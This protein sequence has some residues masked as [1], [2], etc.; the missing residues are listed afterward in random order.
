[1]S[2]YP[3]LLAPLDLGAFTVANRVVMGAMHTRLE[4][5]DRPTERAVAFMRARA[6]GEVGLILTGGHAPSE[7]GRMDPES[8]VLDHES[9]LEHH[10]AVCA[11]V[12]G[13]GSRIVLQI[14]HAGR[15]GQVPSCVGPSAARAPINPYAPRALS[16]EEVWEIVDQFAHTASLARAADYDGVEIMGSE[17]YLISQFAALSTNDRNDEFGGDLQGRLRLPLEILRAVRDAVGPQL[18]VIYRISAL[19]LVDG[20]LTGAETCALARSVEHAGA[21]V[22][23]TGIGWH[24]SRVPTVA[25]SVPRAAWAFAVRS[26]KRAVCVP[27]IASNRINT[28]EV[29]EALLA[30]GTADLVSMARPLL[31]DPN[32]VRKARLGRSDEI[33]P[34]IACNQACLDRIFT[35]RTASCML[36]P[37]AGRE[38]EFPATE[39]PN[40]KRI[41]VVGGGPAGMAFALNAA[42]RGHRVTLFEAAPDLGGQLN[43][44]RRVPGKG[45]FDEALRYF[46]VRL[47]AE[48]VVVRTSTKVTAD[49]LGATE[50]DE[51]V[52]AT[53]V[54]PRRPELSGVDHPKVTSY[55]EILNG[56]RIAG[57]SVAIIGAGG[58]GFD[59][60]EFLVGR[61]DDS[62][63]PKA[64]L[65]AWGV[66]E[67]MQ[68]PGGLANGTAPPTHDRV[69]AVTM[70]QR[71]DASLGRSLGKSTG[72]ILKSRLRKA[73]VEM[74]PG[75]T[76]HAIDDEGLHFTAGRERRR[77]DVDTVVICAGQESE[78]SLYDELVASG[79]RPHI[80]GGAH[81][82]AE[83]DAVAAIDQAT[84]LAIEI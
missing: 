59:V 58:I 82:A 8:P 18:L 74:V 36:N 83:L 9:Q 75:A 47:R 4:T 51:L 15:Y 62:T 43:L 21:D 71:K 7:A 60:A 44:A 29:A 32:F 5:L 68:T 66:D 72:W 26:I 20:G 84:R 1:L 37:R 14:L 39:A 77:I 55:V 42:E 24:E 61:E 49:D 16:T 78:R 27:V 56:A 10:R 53:G 65:V 76:Y 3:H 11:A 12:H 69:R 30:D 52:I 2:A 17:G 48:G 28:P 33:N 45:E 23:N 81:T 13:A 22:I 73:G 6:R 38:I 64:F 79:R 35:D 31:V 41:G 34:C 80:I 57:R 46:R 50:F 40:P 19:D 67:A 54:T 70:L 63:S 25:A